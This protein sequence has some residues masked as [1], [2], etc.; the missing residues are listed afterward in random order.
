MEHRARNHLHEWRRYYPGAFDFL[1]ECHRGK[2]QDGLP[3]WPD[4]CYAPIAAAASAWMQWGYGPE[5]AG[6]ITGLAAWRMTQGIYRIDPSLYGSLI[7]TPVT[8]D[9]PTDAI[10][11]LPEW[12]VYVETPESVSYADHPVHGAFAWLEHDVNHGHSELRML[13][14]IDHSAGP[15]LYPCIIH[16]GGTIEEGIERARQ[17]I[18]KRARLDPSTATDA[19]IEPSQKIVSLLLYMCSVVDYQ[20]NGQP[21]LPV[22]PVGKKTKRGLRIFAPQNSTTWDVGVR[23]GAALRA[24]YHREQAE[25]DATP[26]GRRVRPHVRRAHWHTFLSGP[27]LRDGERIPPADR[28]R[29]VRWVPPIPVNVESLDA[30]PAAVRKVE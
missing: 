4:W 1:D 17:E 27:R 28:R 3:D 12:C 8:G 24:A 26:T 11:Q 29:Y 25:Q 20:R 19:W 5:N 21:G 9:L 16:L 23:M 15:N 7:D 2:G 14:D 18:L 13:L 22:N 6:T 30:L 10:F